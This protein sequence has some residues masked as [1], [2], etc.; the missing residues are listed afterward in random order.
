MPW[1]VVKAPAL[2]CRQTPG[3][4]EG[5]YQPTTHVCE[6]SCM[7]AIQSTRTTLTN[8]CVGD[9]TAAEDNVSLVVAGELP[10]V[11]SVPP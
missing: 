5:R 4:A 6:C 11:V 7:F 2:S 8:D 1:Q 9:T 10:V 3:L